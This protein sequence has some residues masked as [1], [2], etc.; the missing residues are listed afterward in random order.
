[1]KLQ[2]CLLLL[3]CLSLN[4]ILHSQ[5]YHINKLKEQLHIGSTLP[6]VT[7]QLLNNKQIALSQYKNKLIILDFFQSICGACISSLPNLNALQEQ[8]AGKLQVLLIAGEPVTTL[9]SFF[10]TNAY[11]IVISHVDIEDQFFGFGSKVCNGLVLV[12]LNK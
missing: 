5:P 12:G 9:K 6:P 11:V 1:M 4:N 8:N 3:L 2:S 7:V 10:A